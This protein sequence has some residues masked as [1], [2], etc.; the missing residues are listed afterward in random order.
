[1]SKYCPICQGEFK[2]GIKVCPTD[3]IELLSKT[4]AAER[5]ESLVNIYAAENEIEGERIRAFLADDGIAGQESV[6]GIAQMPVASDKRFI[7]AVP[8]SDEKAAR[9][10]IERARKDKVISTNGSFL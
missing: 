1:M 2:K 8:Q 5:T 3:H 4:A 6:T 9:K 10:L 7:I